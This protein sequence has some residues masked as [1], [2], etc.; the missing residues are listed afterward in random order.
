MEGGEEVNGAAVV[1]RGDV[2]EVLQL[3]E[4][5]LDPVAQ[6]VSRLVRMPRAGVPRAN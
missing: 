6:L 5:A 3:V 4:E 1:A 2:S